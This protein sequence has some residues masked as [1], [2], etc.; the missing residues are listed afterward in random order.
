VLSS[1]LFDISDILKVFDKPAVTVIIVAVIGG[2][3]KAGSLLLSGFAGGCT[4]EDSSS[5][6]EGTEIPKL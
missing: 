6:G 1:C 3:V 2:A 4:P 5:G